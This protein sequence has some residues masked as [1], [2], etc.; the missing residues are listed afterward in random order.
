MSSLFSELTGLELGALQTAIGVAIGVQAAAALEPVGTGIRQTSYGVDPNLALDPETA[1]RIVAQALKSLGWGEGEAANSGIAA[2]RFDLLEQVQ[3]R[4]PATG[5]LLTLLRRGAI[6]D[7]LFSHGLRKS[8][9][10][11]DYDDAIAALKNLPLEPA[12]VAKAIHRNIMQGAGLLLV[13]PSSTP[14]KVPM[15]PPSPLDPATEAAWSGVDHERLRIMV[16]NAGLPPGIIQGLELLNRGAITED[17][18]SRLVGESNMR[19][20]W[21]NVLLELR[22]RLLTPHEYA[23]LQIRGQLSAAE[24]DAGAALS[25][26]TKGDAELLYRMLGRAGTPHAV[27]TGLARGGKY[28]GSY[29]NVPEPW[30]TAIERSNTIEEMAELAYANR[31]SYPSGFQIKAEAPT[32]GHDATKQLLLEVGW[33]PKWAEFFAAQWAGGSV[34]AGAGK[35]ET[36][37]EL[38]DEYEGGF[39]TEAEYRADLGTLGYAG[40]ELDLL[41]HLGDARRAKRYREKVVDAIAAAFV[42]F[43]LDET[44]AV[45]E[46][47]KVNVT[48]DA[49]TQLV[50]LWALQRLDTIRELTPA[51]VKKAHKDG[52][53][54]DAVALQALEWLH[55]SA[56]DAETFLAE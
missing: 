18:F 54:S 28:P 51:Q 6:D 35:S 27:T 44:A 32:I 9:L 5:E 34:T 49:A 3:L 45:S 43:R 53:L 42:A 13:E 7:A 38:A 10:E 46:L 22:R 8:Q 50:S 33:S 29:A 14:G 52:I 39:I 12:E 19:Q 37:A 17:D 20:E 15:V 1:A 4:A 16:G 21:G 40:H 2:E 36:A 25:G 47:A 56:A 55:Y 48:G 24:R 23:E 26:M 41:V 11:P 31:Y 30:R